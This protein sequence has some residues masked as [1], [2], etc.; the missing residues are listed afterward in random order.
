MQFEPHIE[1]AARAYLAMR[2]GYHENGPGKGDDQYE[3][4]A[5][6]MDEAFRAER[7]PLRHIDFDGHVVDEPDPSGYSEYG[8]HP[9]RLDL[10]RQVV[11]CALEIAILEARKAAGKPINTWS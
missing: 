7:F 6:A 4:H 8:T 3:K 11:T 1:R 10:F 2:E 5:K 9:E